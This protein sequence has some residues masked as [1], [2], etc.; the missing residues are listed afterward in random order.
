[1]I[2]LRELLASEHTKDDPPVP[3]PAAP[4]T[5]TAP[6]PTDTTATTTTHTQPTPTTA[7]TTDVGVRT[8]SS[9]LERGGETLPG[10]ELHH[11]D[12]GNTDH[13]VDKLLG[14]G[15]EEVCV[16][17]VCVRHALL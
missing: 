15:D 8:S 6:P 16:G 4:D 10:D 9:P 17:R 12:L 2:P 3:P 1:M 13:V 5:E 11:F 14:P 7:A